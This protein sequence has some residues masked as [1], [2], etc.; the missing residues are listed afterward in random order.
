MVAAWVLGRYV[1]SQLYGVT[2]KDPV[3]FAVA[4]LVLGVAAMTSGY[5][6]ARRAARMNGFADNRV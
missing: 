2:A 5:I 1:Q 3:V 6:P 4:L